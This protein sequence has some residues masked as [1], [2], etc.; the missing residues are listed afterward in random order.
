[1]QALKQ[2]AAI[3]TATYLKLTLVAVDAVEVKEV[4]VGVPVEDPV[5]VKV[6]DAEEVEDK[7]EVMTTSGKFHRK[8]LISKHPCNEK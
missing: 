5:T 1:V 3:V 6:A 7:V 4:A 2:V 8:Y